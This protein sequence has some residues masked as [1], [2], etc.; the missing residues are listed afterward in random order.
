[1]TTEIE[2]FQLPIYHLED[3]IKLE[4]HITNDLELKKTETET[5]LYNNVFNPGNIEYANST[6]PLWSEYYTA[7]KQFLKDSQKLISA[8]IP[9]IDISNNYDNIREIWTEI[10]TETSFEEKYQY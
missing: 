3:K 6:L 2:Q 5:S 4:D 1:M 8:D 7:N 9:I 10:T